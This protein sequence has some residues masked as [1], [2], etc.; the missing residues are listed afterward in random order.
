MKYKTMPEYS[1]GLIKN[2]YGHAC[3]SIDH[4]YDEEEYKSIVLTNAELGRFIDDLLEIYQE[5]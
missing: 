3:I 4:R 5:E 2:I 1:L